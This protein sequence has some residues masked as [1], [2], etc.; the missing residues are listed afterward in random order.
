[1]RQR[2]NETSIPHLQ[3]R[4]Y[5][6]LE[7]VS[8]RRTPESRRIMKTPEVEERRRQEFE[9]N[10]ERV[11]TIV[12]QAHDIGRRAL[13]P[14]PSLDPNDPLVGAPNFGGIIL[15]AGR[16]GPIVRNTVHI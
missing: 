13:R 14:Q 1:V 5:S 8:M 10:V 15:I 3:T 9:A 2:A 11:G 7:F 12:V 4:W 6:P 16:T